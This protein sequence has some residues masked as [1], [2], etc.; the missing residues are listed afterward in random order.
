MSLYEHVRVVA[1][2]MSLSR[3][4]GLVAAARSRGI[5]TSVDA[6]LNTLENELEALTE[7][8]PS[9]VEARRR[10]AETAETLD[11]K[12]ER[13]ATLR[14]RM[15]EAEDERLEREYRDAIGAL[16][17]AETEHAAA[18]EA[19]EAARERART[20][21]DRRDRR[22][23]LEDRVGNLRRQAR[24]ELLEAIRR[25]ADNAV[26]NVPDCGA[27]R[28]EDADGVSAALALVRIGRIRRPIVVACGRFPS[29]DAAERWLETPVYRVAPSE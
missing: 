29:R 10:V 16:S 23:R 28:F 13:V 1:P 22:L 25:K 6:E 26:S 21:R 19:L 3:R 4:S 9:R 20:V 8:V 5:E 11:A 15:R 27:K 17:E 18:R 12:R 14:G 2:G 7:P 24:R